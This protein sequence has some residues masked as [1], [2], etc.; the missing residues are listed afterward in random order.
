MVSDV[1]DRGFYDDI[2]AAPA[3]ATVQQQTG[4]EG[5]RYLKLKLSCAN[6]GVAAAAGRGLREAHGKENTGKV[7]VAWCSKRLVH[8]R[9]RRTNLSSI[10]EA[11]G[12]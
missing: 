3:V 6:Q 4:D 1:I 12:R 10:Q 5:G 7:R 9:G 11:L 2:K 8:N